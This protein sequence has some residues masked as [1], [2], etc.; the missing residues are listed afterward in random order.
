LLVGFMILH[1]YMTTT[2]ITVLENIKSM[3]TG[4]KRI[5]AQ[6]ERAGERGKRIVAE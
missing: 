5:R 4:R 1:I 3:I 6:E 2:G